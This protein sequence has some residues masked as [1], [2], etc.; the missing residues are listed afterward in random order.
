MAFTLFW[1]MNSGGGQKEKWSQIFIEAPR[2]EAEVIFFN[3]FGHNPHRVTCTCCGQDY[4]VTE[5]DS[6]EE[7]AH[8]HRT[9]HWNDEGKV[10]LSLEEFCSLDHVLVIRA[11]DIK[12]EERKGSLP[13]QGYVWVD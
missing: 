1:D 3:R 11:E 13:T 6:L 8:Y 4:S 12:P 7:A 2:E 9:N 5:E 10:S